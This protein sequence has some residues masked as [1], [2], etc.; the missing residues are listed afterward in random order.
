MMPAYY[1]K[2]HRIAVYM[3]AFQGYHQP[4]LKHLVEFGCQP[5]VLFEANSDQAFQ[6]R[7]SCAAPSKAEVVF[8]RQVLAYIVQQFKGE[9]SVRYVRPRNT[10]SISFFFCYRLAGSSSRP[11]PSLSSSKTH[12]TSVSTGGYRIHRMSQNFT[13]GELAQ[14][15]ELAAFRDSP[16]YGDI[17]LHVV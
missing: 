15:W 13:R 9:H 12:A 3:I 17:H 1:K 6:A 7:S 16:S 2:L 10:Q 4:A 11:D 5:F 8:C 14:S